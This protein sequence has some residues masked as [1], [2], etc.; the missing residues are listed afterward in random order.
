MKAIVLAGGYPQISLIKELKKRDYEVILIDWNDYPVAR[1]YADYFYKESTLDVAKVE[2]I[3]VKEKVSLILT[4]CTDQALLTMTY[5][6]EKLNLPCYLSYETACRITDKEQMK[7]VFEQKHILTA[8]QICIDEWDSLTDDD[9]PMIVKPC[10]CNSSKGVKKVCDKAALKQAAFEAKAASRRGVLIAEKYIDGIE[11]TVDAYVENKKAIIMTVSVNEKLEEAEGFVNFRTVNSGAINDDVAKEVASVAQQ[12]ADAFELSDTPL[13]FQAIYDGDRIYVI[14]CSAR[15]GGGA[16]IALLKEM[17]G[18]DVAENIVDLTLGSADKIC[19]K[20]RDTRYFVNDYLYCRPGVL[21]SVEGLERAKEENIIVD[22]YL[23]KKKGTVFDKIT[24]CGDRVAGFSIAAD[25]IEE[26]NRK[27]KAV[28]SCI[29]VFDVN[30][31]DILR[32]DLLTDV[33]VS[34]WQIMNE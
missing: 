18:F 32:H 25:S 24:T 21:E 2:E 5:I 22:Y 19:V 33:D 7:A 12:I 6:S 20:P 34:K 14:E 28:N 29:R 3:A 10:D 16:K 8:K 30:G 1:D 4:V 27:Q 11:L 26:L 15:S 13:L 17:A 31:V 9:F 23:Y